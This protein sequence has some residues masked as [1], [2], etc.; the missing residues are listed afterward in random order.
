[1]APQCNS[2][3]SKMEI[4]KP[5]PDY[6]EDSTANRRPRNA[7]NVTTIPKKRSNRKSHK[8]ASL[9]I[10]SK[11]CA[12]KQRKAKA[13]SRLKQAE[14]IPKDNIIQASFHKTVETLNPIRRMDCQG[15]YD[16]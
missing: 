15:D 10:S 5:A 11:D 4:Q 2:Q 8:I 3:R 1:M 14:Q 16:P 7:R 12:K 6:K 9:F 13:Y